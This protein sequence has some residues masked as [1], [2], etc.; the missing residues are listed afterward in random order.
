MYSRYGFTNVYPYRL[1]LTSRDRTKVVVPNTLYRI[2]N[3]IGAW[4]VLK[5]MI[6]F[7]D[8]FGM[9]IIFPFKGKYKIH[10]NRFY[11]VSGKEA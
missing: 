1:N 2:F 9:I 11:R 4:L 5:I 3:P 8:L 10:T 7:N 6:E